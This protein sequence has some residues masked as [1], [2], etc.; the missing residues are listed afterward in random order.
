MIIPLLSGAGLLM[1]FIQQPQ[2]PDVPRIKIRDILNWKDAYSDTIY[3]INFW[4]TWCKPCI[5]ELPDLEK[6]NAEFA[7]KKVKVILVSNDFKKDLNTK[8]LPFVKQKQLKST[9]VFMDEPTPNDWIN[10]VNESWSGSIPATLI[11]SKKKGYEEFYERSL[12]YEE[13]KEMLGALLLTK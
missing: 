4:A 7:A 9:V 12:S 6:I 5:E 1:S 10:L 13:L 8:L 11:V 3:V 2:Q